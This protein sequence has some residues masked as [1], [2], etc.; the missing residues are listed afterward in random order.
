MMRRTLKGCR[1]TGCSLL[2]GSV[3]L[4]QSREVGFD[5]GAEIVWIDY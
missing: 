3:V 4:R 5:K 2:D 1:Q